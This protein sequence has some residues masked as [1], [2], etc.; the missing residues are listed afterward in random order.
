[1]ARRDWNSESTGTTRLRYGGERA[2]VN[3]ILRMRRRVDAIRRHRE[4][5]TLCFR[6]SVV[7]PAFWVWV[8]SLHVIGSGY[9][10]GHARANQV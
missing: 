2:E 1:M 6:F 3:I 9:Y 7:S 10:F 4:D 5:L 8:K